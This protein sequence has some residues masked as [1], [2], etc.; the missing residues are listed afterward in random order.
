MLLL[1][2][3]DG[4]FYYGLVYCLLITFTMS[5]HSKWS[6]IK[7]KKGVADVQRGK[8]F[9]KVA[10]MISVAA[11]EGGDPEMNSKLRMAIE[12][13]REVNMPRD[14]IERAI[15]RGTGEVKGVKIEEISYE[16]YGPGG[17]ALI[18]EVATDNKNRTLSEIK[19]ILS[20]FGG[21]LGESGSVKWMFS[22]KG[23]IECEISG[24]KNKNDLELLI[25][26]AGAEDIKKKGEILEIYTKE[27]ELDKVK[28]N[29]ESQGIKI[30]SASL[31]WIAKDSVTIEDKKT[32]EQLE[33][34]FEALDEQEDVQE[35]YSNFIT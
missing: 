12:K 6:Q 28:E 11:R 27:G 8:I 14:N 9:S 5:G 31:D 3:T 22:R 25:I 29:L 19:H 32:K 16:A 23:V 33:K 26:D 18:I 10:K 24:D 17:I 4:V 21:R 20:R 35:I 34:L 7:R 30:K 13:A 2:L 15:K 1:Y